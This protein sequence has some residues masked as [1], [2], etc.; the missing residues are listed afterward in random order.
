MRC[1]GY[2]SGESVASVCEQIMTICEHY[3]PPALNCLMN[4]LSTHDT[5]RALT[6]IAANL[7]TD[8]TVTGRA[9][10]AYRPAGWM[11]GCARCCWAMP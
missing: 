2:L 9:A 11:K 6:V 3:P 10:A 8:G 1:W 5:E 4:F 7:P